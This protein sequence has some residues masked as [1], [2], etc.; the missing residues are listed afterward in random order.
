MLDRKFILHLGPTNSGKT[1]SALKEF[2]SAGNGIYCS[3]LRMLAG[4][5][6]RKTNSMVKEASI[7]S[8]QVYIVV[9][10]YCRV[11]SVT[12]SLERNDSM[13]VVQRITPPIMWPA[14]LRWPI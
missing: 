12:F 11:L 4:E 1:H 3:P 2:T 8:M 6:Y 10:F 13:G 5:I 7:N 14:Q 9:L